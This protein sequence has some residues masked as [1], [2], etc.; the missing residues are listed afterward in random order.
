MSIRSGFGVC[1]GRMTASNPKCVV[2]LKAA[3]ALHITSITASYVS[4]SGVP[5]PTSFDGGVVQVLFGKYDDDTDSTPDAQQTDAWAISTPN[6]T[7]QNLCLWEGRFAIQQQ[8]HYYFGERGIVLQ[9]YQDYAVILGG[10]IINGAPLP[11]GLGNMI[12]VL[13][14]N[15]WQADAEDPFGV[16][17]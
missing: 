10:P 3:S 2:Q 12:A 5:L 15:G 17:R 1:K 8:Q 13:S 11:P 4:T 7:P 9:A 14:V 6:A 16:L